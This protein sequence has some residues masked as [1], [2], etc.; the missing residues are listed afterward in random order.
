MAR[1]SKRFIELAKRPINRDSFVHEWPEVGLIV[2]DSPYD[3][4][5]SLRIERGKVVEMD[6]IPREKWDM[7][8]RFI[9]DHALN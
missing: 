7:I 2:I 1:R 4:K 3:P 9:A 5:P 8:D 6:G